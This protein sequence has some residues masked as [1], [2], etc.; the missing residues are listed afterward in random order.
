MGN[1]LSLAILA[2]ALLGASPSLAGS[3]GNG[4]AQRNGIKPV[5]KTHYT[6]CMGGLRKIV[7]FTP[8]ITS[9]PSLNKPGLD[10]PFGKYL[11]A[12]YG[13]GSNNG[14]QCFSSEVKADIE[15]AKKQREAEF[16]WKKWKIVETK[17][18]GAAAPVSAPAG[19]PPAHH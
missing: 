15:G 7:Y 9:A 16:V 11:T 12:T 8:V 2:L 1:K 3:S 13:I 18:T 4:A 6:Y 14:G 19:A 17:W 10:I 5:P